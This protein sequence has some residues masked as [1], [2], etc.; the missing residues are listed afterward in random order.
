MLTLRNLSSISLF[1]LR[2]S[3]VLCCWEEEELEHLRHPAS[4]AVAQWETPPPPAKRTRR[5]DAASSTSLEEL[6]QDMVQS[7]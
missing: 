7:D 4:A 3:E 2:L 6:W 1:S 5:R